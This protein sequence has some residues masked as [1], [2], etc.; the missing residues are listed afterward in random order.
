MASR[1][2]F[3]AHARYPVELSATLKPRSGGSSQAVRIQDLGLGGAGLEIVEPA[4]IFDALPER[5]AP[6][7]LEITIASLWD[8]IRLRGRIA[9]LRRGVA[10]R[11]TRAGLRF[12]HR[13][14][15]TIHAILL[16]LGNSS[17]GV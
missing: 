12:E 16:L 17:F 5:E 15:T 4:P 3:R 14:P 13:E 8:P 1:D 2:H 11:A 9:W 7:L 6:I 10:D